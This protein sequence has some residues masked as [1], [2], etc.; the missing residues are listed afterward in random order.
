MEMIPKDQLVHGAY[1]EGECRNASVARWNAETQLFVYL[2]ETFSTY[3][4]ED[5]GYWQDAKPGEHRF[6]E[7]RP[8]ERVEPATE[9][10][11]VV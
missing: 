6:D 9:L 3:F 1:Y 8:Y 11:L 4:H 5:I 10:P 2:R 7:F